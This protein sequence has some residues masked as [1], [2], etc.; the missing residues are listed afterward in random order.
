MSF[1]ICNIPNPNLPLYI[2]K[3]SGAASLH[4]L[5][6]MMYKN[7]HQQLKQA[8]RKHKVKKQNKHTRTSNAINIKKQQMRWDKNKQPK[9]P[10]SKLIKHKQYN[11]EI[12]NLKHELTNRNIS[13]TKLNE[14]ILKLENQIAQM[15]TQK[16]NILQYC[17]SN[18]QNMIQQF[19]QQLS[20]L[21]YNELY[22]YI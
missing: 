4:T 19:E 17:Q 8:R 12:R 15:K 22:I 20:Q 2:L 10:A 13:I 11:K 6:H 5:T 21:H 18:V 9:S 16:Q 1:D 7:K 3:L 14:K